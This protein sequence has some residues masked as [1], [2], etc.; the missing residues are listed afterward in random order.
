MKPRERDE[1]AKQRELKAINARLTEHEGKMRD[2]LLGSSS[3]CRR[4]RPARPTYS[5][6]PRLSALC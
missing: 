2:T 3:E 1:L 4:R 6:G 5:P